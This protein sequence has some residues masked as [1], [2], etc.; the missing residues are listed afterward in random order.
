MLKLVRKWPMTDLF[1]ALH[2]YSDSHIYDIGNVYII[3]MI[4]TIY[5]Y[6]VSLAHN[7][8]GASYVLVPPDSFDR[9]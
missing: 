4:A 3:I 2:T 7:L 5:K 6:V 1:L 9:V 8:E